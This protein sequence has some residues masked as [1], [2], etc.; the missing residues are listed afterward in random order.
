MVTAKVEDDGTLWFVTDKESGIAEDISLHEQV[1]V[2]YS[3]QFADVYVSISGTAKQI[4][5]SS[6]KN[7]ALLTAEVREWLPE[8]VDESQLELIKVTMDHGQFWNAQDN[9]HEFFYRLINGMIG[10]EKE[11]T[12]DSAKV[13][14]RPFI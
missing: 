1:N 8:E 10:G 11:K 5:H 6:E 14:Y 7:G 2:S 3:S 4:E 13:S 12:L 9:R